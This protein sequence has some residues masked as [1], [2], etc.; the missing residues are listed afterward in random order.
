MKNISKY[1]V[2]IIILISQ[3]T[4][5]QEDEVEKHPLLTDKFTFTGGLFLPSKELRIGVNGEVIDSDI[6]LGKRFDIEEYQRTFNVGFDWRFSRKWTLSADVFRINTVTIADLDE[7][8]EWKDYIF[9]GRAELGIDISVLRTM[10]SRILSQGDKHEFGVGLNYR[11]YT[12][13]L[14]VDK[15]NDIIDFKGSANLTYNGPML[16]VNFNF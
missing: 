15:S 10:V 11:Y 1:L 4:F 14:E 7:P 13:N 8:I 12:I 6:D 16:M 5:S 2:V 3:F 9:D